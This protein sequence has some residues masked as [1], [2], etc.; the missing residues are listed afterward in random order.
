[1]IGDE[2]E[3][4]WLIAGPRPMGSAEATDRPGIEV[5]AAGG[6]PWRRDDAGAVEVLVIHRPRYNDWSFPKGKRD[7]SDESDEACA[8]REV[9]EETGFACQLG[10]ELATSF[11]RDRKGRTKQVRYW[12]MTVV[13]AER[14]PSDDEVDVMRWLPLDQ[15]H[16]RLS[17]E[18]D[19]PV[20]DSFCALVVCGRL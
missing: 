11:Y 5:F 19:R 3:V 10:V 8:L 12:T 6:I 9:T 2:P 7:Q 18:R 13:D 20:F 4:G 1:M 17:Y 14:H 16:A 15:V